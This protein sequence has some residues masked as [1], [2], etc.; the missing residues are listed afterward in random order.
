LS[1]LHELP[2]KQYCRKY[3][4]G[5]YQKRCTTSTSITTT[6]CKSL[7]IRGLKSTLKK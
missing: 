4:R 3:K 2:K 5:P 7:R 1:N 6:V